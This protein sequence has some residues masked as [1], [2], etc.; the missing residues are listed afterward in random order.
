MS[1]SNTSG[2]FFTGFILGTLA[3]AAAALLMAPQSG[4]KTRIELKTQFDGLT[5]EAQKQAE[6]LGTEAQ[7]R[8]EKLGVE[9]PKRK[10]TQEES[11]PAP[12]EAE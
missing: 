6:K 7:K 5:S 4:E 11:D 9:L 1:D 12:P 8:A 3:G 2:A 10:G